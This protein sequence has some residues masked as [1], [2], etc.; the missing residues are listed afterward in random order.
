M[1]LT[2]IILTHNE[3]LNIA[4]CIRSVQFADEI[5]V[6]DDSSTDGTTDIAINEGARVIHRSMNNNWGEQRNY[7]LTQA[8]CDFIFFLDAD[9]RV[10]P[11][12]AKEIQHQLLLHSDR[13]FALRRENHFS[14]GPVTHGIL[15]SDRVNRIFP[16]GKGH[17]EGQVHEKLICQL[18]TSTLKGKLIHYPYRD[19]S[20]YWQ[21]FDKYTAI[22]AKKYLDNGRSCSFWKD[23]FLRPLWAFIKVYFINLGFLDGKL[24]WIFSINHYCYTMNKY[25]RLYSLK[26]NGGRI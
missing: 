8:S 2:A 21:K 19:W 16:K 11:Q 26:H 24:G 6:L 7:A 5:L 20:H 9:E 25:V 14:T 3:A 15:R 13:C 18:P 23:I 4:D 17:Y 12:L 1:S 22:S 10:T